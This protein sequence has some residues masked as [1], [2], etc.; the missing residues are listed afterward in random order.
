M[1]RVLGQVFYLPKAF[2]QVFLGIFILFRPVF[3]LF[4]VEIFFNCRV[5]VPK[6]AIYF[7]PALGKG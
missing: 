2:Q 3:C 5:Y 4:A 7:L 6:K 1:G